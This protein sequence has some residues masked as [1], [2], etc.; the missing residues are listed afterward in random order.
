MIHDIDEMGAHVSASGGVDLAPGRAHGI[1]AAVLQLF[2]KQPSRWAE[3]VIDEKTAPIVAR[4][5]PVNG[6]VGA[7]KR[8]FT[9]GTAGGPKDKP[10]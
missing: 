1:D 5:G 7:L 9:G 10:Q 8:W 6:A 2:T 4:L 3:S